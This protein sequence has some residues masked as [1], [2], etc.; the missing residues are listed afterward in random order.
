MAIPDRMVM[1]RN[2]VFRLARKD[3]DKW[4]CTDCSWPGLAAAKRAADD[5]GISL[6]FR[7]VDVDEKDLLFY[8]VSAQKG[9]V[10]YGRSTVCGNESDVAYS[11]AYSERP[12]FLCTACISALRQDSAL[13]NRVFSPE[14]APKAA[15]RGLKK[16]DALAAL[17]PTEEELCME[18]ILLLWSEALGQ[19]ILT[20]RLFWPGFVKALSNALMLGVVPAVARG[21][22]AFFRAVKEAGEDPAA[23]RVI[24]LDSSPRGV[25]P[26]PL[27]PS[28][29]GFLL[30]QC[31]IQVSGSNAYWLR[32]HTVGKGLLRPVRALER[33]SILGRGR[34]FRE[35]DLYF[36]EHTNDW[37]S[38]MPEN[39]PSS[40]GA[41][42]KPAVPADGALILSE[43]DIIKVVPDGLV[44]R[45]L[46]THDHKTYGLKHRLADFAKTYQLVCTMIEK[47]E[48]NPVH[49]Q[50]MRTDV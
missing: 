18:G 33:Q 10:W 19:G 9:H 46:L 31:G 41:T 39:V 7:S 50:E 47:G 26:S 24:L 45:I 1:L 44:Y 13:F 32:V 15:R 40:D 37:R 43:G 11:K 28:A 36:R 21:I 4:A 42:T 48:V 16:G 20:K 14:E 38:G 22:D 5:E 27:Y 35:W 17:K 8:V 49:W 23:V 30:N 2:G 3:G 12:R 25:N 34:S 29:W 6:S